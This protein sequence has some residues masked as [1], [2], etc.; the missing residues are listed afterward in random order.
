MSTVSK[1]PLFEASVESRLMA[2]RLSKAKMGETVTY[3]ELSELIGQDV[4]M[5]RN[6]SRLNTALRTVLNDHRYVFGVVVNEGYKRLADAELSKVGNASLRKMRREAHR[7]KKKLGCVD[8]SKLTQT[9]SVQW[10]LSATM[11]S[12]AEEVLAPRSFKAIE[13]AV[14][15]SQQQLPTAKAIEAAFSNGSK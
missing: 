7:A 10:N 4:R 11:V 15:K 8:L 9:E 5:Q 3:A 14:S 6:K 13:N 1:R 12:F 2:D